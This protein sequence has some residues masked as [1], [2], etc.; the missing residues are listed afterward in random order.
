MVSTTPHATDINVLKNNLNIAPIP[1]P[2]VFYS[3]P[4]NQKQIAAQIQQAATTRYS[5]AQPNQTVLP[6]KVVDNMVN[7]A[8][9]SGLKTTIPVPMAQN[10]SGNNNDGTPK[11]TVDIKPIVVNPPSSIYTTQVYLTGFAQDTA[12]TVEDVTGNVAN[13]GKGLIIFAALIGAAYI[14]K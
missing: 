11:T 10:P 14:L 2:A 9:S 3:Q 13:I 8:R 6:S 5:V 7:S 1:S 12:R 4:E